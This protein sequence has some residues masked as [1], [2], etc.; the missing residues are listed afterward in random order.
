MAW[1]PSHVHP[2]PW[3]HL[4]PPVYDQMFQVSGKGCRV[5][6]KA[7]EYSVRTE[8]VLLLIQRSLGENLN[9]NLEEEQQLAITFF[10]GTAHLCL[11]KI[12][13]RNMGIHRGAWVAQPVR[14]P[15]LDFGSGL[16]LRVMRSSPALGSMLSVELNSL[17]PSPFAPP[18]PNPK[19]N[20]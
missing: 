4:Q 17:S 5:L 13:V 18:P 6:L 19:I 2:G 8:T 15:A 14:R 3:A 12:V 11:G 1:Q 16:D 10:K 7:S 20:K 9:S